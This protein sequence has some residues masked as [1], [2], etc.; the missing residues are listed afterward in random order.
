MLCCMD[1]FARSTLR[2]TSSV[3]INITKAAD[4][5]KYTTSFELLENSHSVCMMTIAC[6]WT[7]SQSLHATLRL[8]RIFITNSP[9]HLQEIKRL[10]FY[11]NKPHSFTTQTCNV[12]F[13]V[14]NK[15]MCAHLVL[16]LHS[17]TF[18][19]QHIHT[20]KLLIDHSCFYFIIILF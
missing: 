17:Q 9:V 11:W 13:I 8:P 12:T 3:A 19:Y 4:S 18:D 10:S 7:L 15:C 1:D 14:Y 20:L 16:L 5:V 6:L 2:W